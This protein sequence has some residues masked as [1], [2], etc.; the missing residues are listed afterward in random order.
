[1]SRE[2]DAQQ[3]QPGR[4]TNTAG[5]RKCENVNVPATKQYEKSD[6]PR[7]RLATDTAGSRKCENVNVPATKQYEKSEVPRTRL[8]AQSELLWVAER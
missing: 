7:T 1:M 3:I 4:E 8:A 6:V 2:L 5:S